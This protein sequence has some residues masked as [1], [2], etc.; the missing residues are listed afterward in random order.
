[1]K[2]KEFLKFPFN[3]I[4]RSS[5]AVCTIYPAG[6]RKTGCSINDVQEGPRAPICLLCLQHCDESFKIQ[7]GTC[8][9]QQF[10]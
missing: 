7:V 4:S 1:M 3:L 9:Q 2:T 10:H 6:W 5:S 8:Q